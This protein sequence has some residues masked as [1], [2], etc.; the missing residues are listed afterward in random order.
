MAQRHE[1]KAARERAKGTGKKIQSRR[2]ALPQW[3]QD[4]LKATAKMERREGMGIEPS[5]VNL[6]ENDGEL[7]VVSGRHHVPLPSVMPPSKRHRGE[8][9][10][11][12]PDECLADFKARVR[13]TKFQSLKEEHQRTSSSAIKK[14]FLTE[15]KKRKKKSKTT[16]G[17]FHIVEFIYFNHSS[18][19]S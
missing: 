1:A 3:A 8:L 17:A 5:S 10:P 9:E 12:Q 15:K 14:A 19:P 13:K 11:Q 18:T 7:E 6:K 2:R 16:T 4:D